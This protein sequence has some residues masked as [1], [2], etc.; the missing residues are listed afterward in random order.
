[1]AGMRKLSMTMTKSNPDDSSVSSDHASSSD[2]S[3]SASNSASSKTDG[4]G[5]RSESSSSFDLARDE[6]KAVNRSKMLML[7]CLFAVCAVLGAMVWF[8]LNNEETVRFQH[9]V[10]L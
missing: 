10:S 9:E 8:I 4:T 7:F 2:H 1:M 6:T 5:H 3:G